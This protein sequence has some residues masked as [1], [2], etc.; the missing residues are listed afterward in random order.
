MSREE[1]AMGRETKKNV[2]NISHSFVLNIGN[3]VFKS[4]LDKRVC[5]QTC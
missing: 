5:I 4:A 1:N 3:V 2:D